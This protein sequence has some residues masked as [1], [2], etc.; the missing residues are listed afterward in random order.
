MKGSVASCV[1]VLIGLVALCPTGAQAGGAS[2]AGTI[3]TFFVCQSINGANVDATVTTHEFDDTVLN[4]G[5]RVGNGV[6]HCRQ[7]NV[8]DDSTNQFLNPPPFATGD[9]KCYSIKTPGSASRSS[10]TLQDAFF[11][12][13]EI[14]SQT[15]PPSFLCAPTQPTD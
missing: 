14:V 7:V 2:G 4:S 12:A 3:S 9:I 10:I 1:A 11:P 8:S 5:I 13:G 6:L 15:A